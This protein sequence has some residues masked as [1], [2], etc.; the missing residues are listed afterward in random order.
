MVDHPY[1]AK[2]KGYYDRFDNLGIP[3]Y[4]AFGF[5]EKN[6]KLKN[7]LSDAA[8]VIGDSGRGV[9]D[10]FDGY[11]AFYEL[12]TEEYLDRIQE[13]YRNAVVDYH[14]GNKS[15]KKW[16]AHFDNKMDALKAILLQTPITHNLFRKTRLADKIIQTMAIDPNVPNCVTNKKYCNSKNVWYMIS[17]EQN[18][19]GLDLYPGTSNKNLGSAYKTLAALGLYLY[20]AEKNYD[21]DTIHRGLYYSGSLYESIDLLYDHLEFKETGF[22]KYINGGNDHVQSSYQCLKDEVLKD[23][24]VKTDLV[25]NLADISY[26]VASFIPDRYKARVVKNDLLF[27]NASI[28]TYLEDSDSIESYIQQCDTTDQELENMYKQG[29][30]DIQLFINA[31]KRIKKLFK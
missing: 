22:K 11:F 10:S 18:A 24:T 5:K 6:E 2:F 21:S 7:A 16:S 20:L 15:F 19:F 3:G 1:F 14:N 9:G 30:G 17:L 25:A 4:E 12:I 31:S 8:A 28:L 26:F 13:P 29:A 23:D 27:A